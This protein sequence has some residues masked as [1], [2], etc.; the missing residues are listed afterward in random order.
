MAEVTRDVSKLHLLSRIV[1]LSSLALAL[2][3]LWFL[4]SAGQAFAC[5]CAEP[6]TPL[7]EIEKFDAVFVGTVFSVQH[8]YDPEGKS[9]T[10]E[11]RTTIGFE[12]STVWKGTVHETMY[13]T[14][15]PTGG[16]CGYTFVAGEEYIVYASES[17]YG[18]DSYTASICSRTALLSD[19]QADLDALGE[20]EAPQAGTK[21]PAPEDTQSGLNAGWVFALVLAAAILI[22]GAGGFVAYA[23]AGRG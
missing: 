17:H 20:G 13:I 8:S 11:D 9:V 19:A 10:P 3:F 12:A 16:S 22:V 7:E 6:G 14:T 15:P 4:A 2:S 23:R 5:K 18:D 21:G 1:G